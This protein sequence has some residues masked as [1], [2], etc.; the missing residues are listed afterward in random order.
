MEG[1]T[2]KTGPG[3]AITGSTPAQAL[4]TPGPKQPPGP[5]GLGIRSSPFFSTY[6]NP[7]NSG[8]I[9]ILTFTLIPAI[10]VALLTLI[11]Q[12]CFTVN[13]KNTPF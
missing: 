1:V 7:S 5:T 4:L 3:L 2:A 11:N 10:R 12:N 9:I 6:I 13:V 8:Y